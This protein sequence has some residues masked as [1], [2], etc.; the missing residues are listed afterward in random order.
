MLSGI[1]IQNMP[2]NRT[3]EKALPFHLYTKEIYEKAIFKQTYTTGM[4][5]RK[6]Y[7]TVS[8]QQNSTNSWGSCRNIQCCGCSRTAARVML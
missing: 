4:S 5:V 8:E 6:I 7:S 2:T 3:Q 1:L